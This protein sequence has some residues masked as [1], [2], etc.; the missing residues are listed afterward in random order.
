MTDDSQTS[1]GTPS[2]T[3][4]V[5]A[6]TSLCVIAAVAIV[7]SGLIH[8]QLYFDG[9]RD[10]PDANLGR[11]FLLNGIGSMVIAIALLAR[12]DLIVRLAGIGLVVGTLIAFALSRSDSGIFGF[13]EQ[14]LEPSP[15]AALALVSEI[16][17][18][19]ALVATFV[20]MVGAGRS[21]PQR[22]L[23]PVAAVVVVGAAV[24]SLLWNREPDAPPAVA[25]PGA[26]AIADFA[27]TPPELSVASGTVI[28]WTNNDGV[29]HT[30]DSDDDSFVSETLTGGAKFSYTFDTAG[31]FDY[32]CGIHPSMAGTITVTD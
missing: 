28:T 27:F 17:A 19:V 12:R 31:T 13:T 20:P 15:Q 2:G 7:I 21:L 29:S 26:I 10:F 14:G 3:R 23:A 22:V 30:V 24:M 5:T 8:L 32:I 4:S 1:S 25:T 16:V 6:G 11:S 9:Y 18:L